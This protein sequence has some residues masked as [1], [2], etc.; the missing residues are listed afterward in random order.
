MSHQ[1]TPDIDFGEHT[2]HLERS[3]ALWADVNERIAAELPIPHGAVVADIGC[4]AGDMTMRFAGRA[5]RVLAVD[6]EPVL[7]DAVRKRVDHAGLGDVVRTVQADLADLPGALPELLHLAWLGHVVHHAG[8]QVAAL[9][10]LAATLLP[11]GTLAIAEGGRM[12]TW[13]PWDVGVGEPGIE[14]RLDVAQDRWFASMRASLP[15][16]VRDPRGWSALLRAAGLVDVTAR[17]WL[18]HRPAPLPEHDRVEVLHA[19]A[20]KVERSR[21]WVEPADLA[22]WERL[23]DPA[24]AAWLGHRDDLELMAVELVYLGRRPE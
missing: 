4:G 11:G 16:S 2:E 20:S 22:S 1:H 9:T 13:L 7:L 5:A 8:D 19:L 18:L 24:D 10:A 3:A 23:L 17:A 6:R 21:Q 15:G 12:P 14:R